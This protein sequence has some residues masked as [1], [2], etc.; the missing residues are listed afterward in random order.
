MKKIFIYKINLYNI[1]FLFFLKVFNFKIFFFNIE[2][3]IR[4]KTLLQFLKYLNIIWIDYSNTENKLGSKINYFQKQSSILAKKEV[5]SISN[6]IWNK[7]LEFFFKQKNFLAISMHEQIRKKIFFSYQFFESAKKKQVKNEKV[8]FWIENNFIS[9]KIINKYKNFIIIKPKILNFLFLFNIIFSFSKKLFK[10]S[11]YKPNIFIKNF[12]KKS[13]IQNK[14]SSYLNSKTIFFPHKGLVN[15]YENKDYFFS[16]NKKSLLHRSNILIAEYNKKEI[17]DVAKKLY[18]RNNQN[19]IYWNEIIP[20]NIFTYSL[21]KRLSQILL[22]NFLMYD[23]KFAFQV[24]GNC[25]KIIREKFRL[26]QFK[27]VKTILVGYEY[28]FPITLAIASKIKNIKLVAVQKR[29]QMPALLRQFIID[30]YFII[31]NK[32]KSDLKNQIYKNMNSIIVGGI[33]TRNNKKINSFNNLNFK[34][35]KKKCLVLDYPSRKNWYMNG[36]NVYV[37]WNENLIFYKTILKIAENNKEILFVIKG[38]NY[39]WLNISY[40]DAIKKKIKHQ[41]NLILFNKNFNW[42]NLKI[43]NFFDFSIARYTSLVDDF[44]MLNKPVIIYDDTD[45][46]SYYINYSNKI[47]SKDF[48]DLNLKVKKIVKNYKSYNHSLTSIRKKFYVKF[49]KKKYNYELG[50]FS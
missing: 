27:K 42:T 4:Y 17:N 36:I 31:G 29:M 33:E 19:V 24:V 5:L 41:K 47:V 21:I 16:K 28:L 1:F 35:Y 50:K 14:N 46:I 37:N 18:Q 12:F 13:V 39:N 22:K 44:L 20:Y 25:I 32:T 40:F 38:K 9:R 10:F 23:T 43:V 45:I 2:K 49:N 34:K 26:S 11:Y 8:Y 48:S 30:K 3:S 15:K 7:E 6:K